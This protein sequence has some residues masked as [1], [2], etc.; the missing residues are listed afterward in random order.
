MDIRF[1]WK[2][3]ESGAGDCHAIYQV[4]GGYILVG[5]ILGTDEISQVKAV[6]EDNNSGIAATETAMFVKANVL[7][8]L[9]E[10]G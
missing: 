1:M 6:G 7:D 10:L 4:D 9:R 5:D 8:R 3:G 2:D